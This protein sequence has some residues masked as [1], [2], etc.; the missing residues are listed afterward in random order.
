MMYSIILFVV[1]GYLAVLILM[2]VAQR[3]L[4]YQPGKVLPPVS[5]TLIPNAIAETVNT[6]DGLALVS[7]YLPPANDM[8]VVVYFQ[9]NAATIANRDYKAAPW[10]QAGYGIWL[11][12]YRGFGGNPGSP[13]EDGLYTDARSVLAMLA[14]RGIGPDRVIL[15]GESLGSGVATHMAKELADQGLPAR[16]LVLEAPFT[17]M[18]DAAQDH[19]PFLPARLLVKDAYD[20]LAKISSIKTSLMIVHGDRDRVVR[21]EHG[22]KLFAAAQRPKTALW[23]KGASHNNLYDFDAGKQIIRF[24][25]SLNQR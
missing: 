13:T 16:G 10:H 18:G 20:S 6:S 14:E 3:H 9:G 17:A 23:I 12:G 4:M 19:Y 25:D 7:W 1:G 21:Q 24:F 15:Y 2:Y 11:V 5:Q 8:P 22:R